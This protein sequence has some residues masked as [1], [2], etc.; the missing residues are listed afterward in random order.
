[1]T[2]F[3]NAQM[4]PAPKQAKQAPNGARSA[5]RNRGHKKTG[6]AIHRVPTAVGIPRVNTK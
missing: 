4:N 5:K 3:Q 2:R 1:M 6:S